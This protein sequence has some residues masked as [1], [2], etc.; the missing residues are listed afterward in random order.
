MRVDME[1]RNAGPLDQKIGQ[2]ARFHFVWR[3]SIAKKPGGA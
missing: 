2:F 1:I 3:Y